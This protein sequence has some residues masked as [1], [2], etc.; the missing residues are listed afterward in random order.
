MAE[1]ARSG[2]RLVVAAILL[3]AIAAGASADPHAAP[4]SAREQ[5]PGPVT[6]PLE[7]SGEQPASPGAAMTPI[8]G[9][10]G[11]DQAGPTPTRTPTPVNIGNFVWDDL[12]GDGRQDAGEPGLAG[13]AVQLWN[14]T[15]TALLATTTTGAAG[16]YTLVAPQ[17]GDYRVRVLLPS[18]QDQFSPKDLAGG[19]D[20]DDS[21]INPSGINLGFTDIISIASNVISITSIDGGIIVFRPPTPTR[22]PTPVNIGNF[23]WFDLNGDGVQGAGEPGLANIAVQLW[24]AEKTDLLDETT[25]GPA[26]NY[27]LV[28]PQ[29]GNYR[30]RVL[31]PAGASITPKD[32][33]AN[34]TSD[35]DIN[36]SGINLGFTDVIAIASNVI[37]ITS[38]DAGLINVPPTPTGTL[39]TATP[40]RT[41]TP[42]VTPTPTATRTPPAGLEQRVFLPLLRS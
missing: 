19:D 12:D 1:P 39:A 14:S 30:V 8:V 22:T 27:T 21:D 28:A 15:K 34:D 18:A 37:S 29:F 35:S 40:T 6:A 17:F 2:R 7:A 16:N 11:T 33:G 32:A 4:V 25:T 31:L 23:V 9:S 20:T 3:F 36:P 10:P 5:P 42:T 38:I 26:G 13:V 41:R 24:N